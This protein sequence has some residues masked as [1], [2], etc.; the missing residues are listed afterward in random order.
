MV[1]GYLHIH[2]L[3][4]H[5]L[6]FSC[7]HTSIVESHAKITLIYPIN[8]MWGRFGKSK[9]RCQNIWDYFFSFLVMK[10][11]TLEQHFYF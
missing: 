11:N 8:V 2:M 5:M 7:S 1:V 3:K 6:A 4:A 9:N 10:R